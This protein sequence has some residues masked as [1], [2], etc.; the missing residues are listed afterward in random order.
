MHVMVSTWLQDG[1][2][3][4]IRI[5]ERVIDSVARRSNRSLSRIAMRN[6]VHEIYNP[7]LTWSDRLPLGVTRSLVSA[8][9]GNLA[10]AIK[11]YGK[12]DIIHAH[13]SYPAGFIAS[14]LSREFG[15]PYV[16][17]E[18]MSPFPFSTMTRNGR[19]RAEIDQAFNNASA[20]IA[21]STALAASIRSFG[22][23]APVVIPNLVD[24]TRFTP[25][26]PAPGKF[27][28]LTVCGISAQKGIGELLNAIALWNP[29]PDEVEF[30][31][32]GDGPLRADYEAMA[33]QLRIADRV[34]WYG[35]VN[36]EAMPGIFRDSH[37]YVMPSLHESFGVVFGE[38]IACG[39]PI[40]ATRCGGPED[41]VNAANGLLVDV[42][43]SIGLSEA[44][45]SLK[46]NWSEYNPNAIRRDFIRR[47]SREAVGGKLTA[48]YK[49]ILASR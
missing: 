5:L 20:T 1:D 23:A 37:A 22:Y 13:V 11:T 9:R 28:F 43:D 35:Q 6:G 46:G 15:I 33:H 3:L 36:R 18:H 4:P 34:V 26:A 44:M 47:F 32:C 14:I 29:S 42:G 8:H 39:K 45:R 30:H 12:I 16:L 38:A 27:K 41:I 21:V 10:L 2:S 48:M 31:V 40:I 19:P 25:A 7:A 24:E 17:T 49:K